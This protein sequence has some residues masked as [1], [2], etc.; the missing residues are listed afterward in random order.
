MLKLHGFYGFGNGN[1][2]VG[3]AVHFVT[4]AQLIW[5]IFNLNGFLEISHKS[6]YQFARSL[7]IL[8][9]PFK[10]KTPIII[11]HIPIKL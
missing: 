11:L 10:H 9:H 8:L 2:I 7:L 6:L 4:T 5:V 1:A 3:K